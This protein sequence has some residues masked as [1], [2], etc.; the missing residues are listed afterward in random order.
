MKKLNN[1]ESSKMA[2]LIP[3]IFEELD[4]HKHVFK[5]KKKERKLGGSRERRERKMKG[6]EG[7]KERRRQGGE[8]G[9]RRKEGRLLG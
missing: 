2:K 7:G 4:I 3:K 1:E 8:E 5:N 9:G 6:W